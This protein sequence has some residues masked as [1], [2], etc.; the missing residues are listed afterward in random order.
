MGSLAQVFL[1]TS[2]LQTARDFYEEAVGLEPRSVGDDSVAYETGACE[3]KLQ[4]DFDAEQLAAFGLS[5]PPAEERGAGAVLVVTVDRSLADV[6]EQIEG[7]L[8]DTGGEL[9]TEPQA[10]PWGGRIF[11]VRDPDGYVLEVRAAET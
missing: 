6:Y 3:L 2:D 11:L 5:E 7:A 8:A 4:A 9:L 1:T 10:V